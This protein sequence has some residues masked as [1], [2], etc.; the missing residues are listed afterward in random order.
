MQPTAH[1]R[2]FLRFIDDDQT[3]KSYPEKCEQ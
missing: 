2:L 1:E 3:Y